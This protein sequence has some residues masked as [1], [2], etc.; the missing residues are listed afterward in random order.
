VLGDAAARGAFL[1]RFEGYAAFVPAPLP[2][3]LG[4]TRELAVAMFLS[5]VRT[6]RSMRNVRT[7]ITGTTRQMIERIQEIPYGG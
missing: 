6:V 5:G 2:P 1:E 3:R 4:F 7:W